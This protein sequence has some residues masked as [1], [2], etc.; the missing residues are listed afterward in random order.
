MAAFVTSML[1][2][3][4]GVGACLY[5]GHRRPLGTPLTWGE[6]FV[7]ATWGFAMMVVAYGVVPHQWLEF[8]DNELLWRPDRVLMGFSADGLK[9]GEEAANLVGRG[10]VLVSYQTM[11]DI[12][13]T[14]LYVV[15]LA[16]QMYMWAA[17]QRRGRAQAGAVERTSRFG[18]PLVRKA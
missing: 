4:V 16:G 17:W 15:F 9:F 11:R 18:R 7:G 14:L 12:V 8:A 6:A 2:L 13:A 5:F 1:I 10:R 3:I